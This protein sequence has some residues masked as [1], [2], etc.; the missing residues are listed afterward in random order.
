MRRRLQHDIAKLKKNILGLSALV[1]DRLREAVKSIV[2]RDPDRA[3]QVIDGDAE[4]D[5]MEVDLEEECLKTLALHQPVAIDLRQVIAILKLNNDLER[6]GDLS[7]NIAES[8]ISL[9][10]RR[11]IP[12]PID[13]TT[14]CI[15]VQSMLRKVLDALVNLDGDLALEICKADDEVDAYHRQIYEIVRDGI[16]Q[17]PDRVD[18]MLEA[19]DVTGCLERI[20]DH[21]T[22]IAEDIIYLIDGEIIRHK[23]PKNNMI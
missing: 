8:A 12:I 14:M 3:Q 16:M 6:I 21:C 23:G 15:K 9:S 2:E 11:V 4:I 13:V 22:N 5:Q 20:A 10:R 1:E 18:C 17:Y 7:V 19:L